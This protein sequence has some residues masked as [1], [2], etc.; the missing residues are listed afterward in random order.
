M[1]K[2][3]SLNALWDSA[4]PTEL[5]FNSDKLSHLPEPAK[6][7][8]EHAIAPGTKIASAVRWKMHGEI[9]SIHSRASRLL[10]TWTDLECDS[11]DE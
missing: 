1:T 9:N 7:Y 3:I 6:R 8:L 4:T 2:S 11:M 10:G 5:L